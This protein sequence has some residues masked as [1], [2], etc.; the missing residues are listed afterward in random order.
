MDILVAFFCELE[1]G[2]RVKS[3]GE[4]QKRW[5]SHYVRGKEENKNEGKRGSHKI[6]VEP[7]HLLHFLHFFSFSSRSFFFLSFLY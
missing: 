4:K 1:I 7:N 6:D 3:H 5:G 2:D